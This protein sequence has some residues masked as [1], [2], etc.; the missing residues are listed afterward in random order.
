ML[1]EYGE[2]EERFGGNQGVTT[3]RG[4]HAHNTYNLLTFAVFGSGFTRISG[5][6]HPWDWGSREGGKGGF[7]SDFGDYRAKLDILGDEKGLERL[8]THG[9]G[10]R[11][12]NFGG[13]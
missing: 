10:M 9:K 13:L 3:E 8:R 1:W 6:R 12:R 4:I 2:T 5:L 11:E 7:S